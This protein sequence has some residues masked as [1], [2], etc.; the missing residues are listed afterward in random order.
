MHFCKKIKEQGQTF[1]IKIK[2][3]GLNFSVKLS[4][5]VRKIRTVKGKIKY[6]KIPIISTVPIKRTLSPNQCRPICLPSGWA[7]LM[8]KINVVFL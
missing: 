4:I 1:F 7:V 8:L 6:S 3:H 5:R 2:Q